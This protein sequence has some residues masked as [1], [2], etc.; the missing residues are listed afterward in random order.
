MRDSNRIPKIL[1]MVQQLW[2]QCPDQRFW[3]FLSNLGGD[4]IE[5]LDRKIN[6]MWYV[7]DN[8]TQKA[9]EALLKEGK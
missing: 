7:E 9:L 2:L 4:V 5:K 8:E 3:Q 1:A 6:D